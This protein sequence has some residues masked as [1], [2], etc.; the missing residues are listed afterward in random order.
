MTQSPTTHIDF[1][2]DCQNFHY[3]ICVNA[4]VQFIIVRGINEA[5]RKR[6]HNPTYM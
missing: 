6:H 5:V 3:S 4:F 2:E 1:E